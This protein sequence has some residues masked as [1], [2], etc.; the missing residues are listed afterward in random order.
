MSEI[1]KL[2]IRKRSALL[3]LVV[4]YLIWGSV[5]LRWITEFIEQDHPQ[6]LAISTMLLVYGVLLGF[7][8]LITGRS[9]LRAHLYLAFQTA[10]VLVASLFHY[11]LDFFALLY[12]PLCGQAVFLF[13]PRVALIWL[14]LLILATIL[15]Q[16]I[17]FGLPGGIP[18]ILLY[19]AGLVFV[20][21]FSVLTLRA[22]ASRQRSEEL[23]QELQQAHRQLQDYSDQAGAL[24]VAEER[25]RLARELHDSVAQTLYGISLQAEAAGRKLAKGQ[26]QVVEEYLHEIGESSQE[27]L[28]ETRLLIFEL[29]SP[30]IEERG[31]AAAL[32][33]R[34]DAVEIRSGLETH[35]NIDLIDQLPP[36]VETGIY[37]I[38]REALNNVLK[39]AHASTLSLSLTQK[40]G[41]LILEITDDGCGFNINDTSQSG[42]MGLQGMLERTERIGGKLEILSSPERGT[43]VRLEVQM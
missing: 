9:S 36:Q 37:G 23:L 12:L 43:T 7:E 38:A 8:P 27:T 4:S 34:L 42:N 1:D 14:G 13:P 2:K 17:Q 22:E 25:N 35:I 32:R 15:G 29:R 16:S 18:F 10:L 24:A 31:L 20:A 41:T 3:F 28:A 6:L 39:H 19:T 33:N 21:A 30:V 26:T 5:T 11:E 40:N